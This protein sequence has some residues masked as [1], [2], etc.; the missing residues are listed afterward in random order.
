MDII[1]KSDSNIQLASND[2][3]KTR[4]KTGSKRIAIIHEYLMNNYTDK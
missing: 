4:F 2:Y 1:G 3:L